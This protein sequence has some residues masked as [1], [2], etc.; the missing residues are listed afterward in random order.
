MTDGGDQVDRNPIEVLAAEFVDRHRRGEHPTVAEY[1]EANPQ[2]AAEIQD[3]FPTILAME[4]LKTHKDTGSAPRLNLLGPGPNERLGDYILLREIGRGGMG[5]VYEAEQES[6][7][8]RVALKVLPRQSFDEEKK[9]KRFQQEA[10]TAARLHHTNIVPIF[11]VGEQDG[12]HYYV[13]Q[14]IPGLGLDTVLKAMRRGDTG[15]SAYTANLSQNGSDSTTLLPAQ[16][17]HALRTGHFRGRQE[18]PSSAATVAASSPQATPAAESPAP[19]ADADGGDTSTARDTETASASQTDGPGA[20]TS[21]RSYWRSVVK[22]GIQVADAMQYAH[23]QGTLHRDI[24][25]ANLILDAHGVVWVTDFGLARVMEQAHLTRS[26]DVVG[27]LQY[28]APEQFRGEYD[29]RSDIYCLGLTL[30]ELL[31]LQPAHADASRSALIHKVTHGTPTPP[32]KLRPGIPEDLEIIVLKAIAREASHRYQTAAELAED[33]RNF[34]EDRPIK[35]RRT[36]AL[37]HAWRWCRRNKAV[38]TLSLVAVVLVMATTV[39]G[40]VGWVKTESAYQKEAHSAKR[41]EA[42]LKLSLKAFADIFDEIAGGD[43]LQPVTEDPNGTDLESLAG[44]DTDNTETTNES[45]QR[46]LIARTVVSEQDAELLQKILRFY[47]RFA[48]ANAGNKSLQEETAKA[49]FRIGKIHLHLRHIDKARQAF[50]DALKMYE[51]LGRNETPGTSYRDETAAIHNELGKTLPNRRRRPG[52][53][54]Q[55]E[56]LKVLSLMGA[57]PTS[58]EKVT[59]DTVRGQYELARA[60]RF[61]ASHWAPLPGQPLESWPRTRR[62]MLERSLELIEALLAKDPENHHFRLA[63]AMSCRT[64]AE[65]YPYQ[66]GLG[67][68]P[69]RVK[70]LEAIRVLESLVEDFPSAGQFRHE[71]AGALATRMRQRDHSDAE[72]SEKADEL[73]RATEIGE[74]LIREFPTVTTYKWTLAE[75]SSGLGRLLRRLGRYDEAVACYRRAIVLGQ[76]LKG[77]SGAPTGSRWWPNQPQDRINLARTLIDNKKGEEAVGE[78]QT[79][80]NELRDPRTLQQVHRLLAQALRL[81]GDEA[82]AKEH[83]RQAQE[84]ATRPGRRGQNR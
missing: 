58:T 17:V 67:P 48:E 36:T 37:E 81:T 35:A 10:Q 30:Y 24:K 68:A 77:V 41:A 53:D 76:D 72:R 71:L 9:L 19:T 65:L 51:Q 44:T 25:P 29:A 57:D 5:I 75:H 33:L 13:M 4:R 83:E 7:G 23:G 3:L 82:R 45:V 69:A 15:A 8:R 55:K 6:L 12:F 61:L 31:T 66:R 63:K 73:Q 50:R 21:N 26:G 70:Q 84:A 14:F 78:L 80:V 39:V 40:Y 49:H 52:A 28:M 22:I 43:R 47:D 54:A 1:A 64:L 60:Y 56:Y 27:T 2:L 32:R 18:A 74:Q 46:P 20:G 42:N 38:A 62:H 11:G 34:L 16:A 79:Y 59:P